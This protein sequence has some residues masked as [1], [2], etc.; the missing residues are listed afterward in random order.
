MTAAAP[1]RWLP[2][3][4]KVTATT[5]MPTAIAVVRL[6]SSGRRPT[7]ILSA[8]STDR[9]VNQVTL[10]LFARYGSAADYT[11]AGQAELERLIEPTGFFRAKA[12]TLISLGQALCDRF[13]GAVP[14][15]LE[16]LVTLPGVGRKTA[17][18]VLGM[19]SPSRAS[20]WIPMLPGWRGGLAGRRTPIRT[21]SSATSPHCCPAR[22]E[23]QRSIG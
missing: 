23:P 14:D 20:R 8:R 11:A 9:L 22:S 18:L 2:P 19:P 12:E 16:E 17:N 6:S 15:T 13:D 7:A 21:S 4:R 5:S 3:T 10:V 1:C